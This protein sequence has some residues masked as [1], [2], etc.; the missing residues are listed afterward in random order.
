MTDYSTN[1]VG[2]WRRPHCKGGRRPPWRRPHCR[3]RRPTPRAALQEARAAVA[4]GP[5]EGVAQVALQEERGK[6]RTAGNQGHRGAWQPA[7]GRRGPH[8]KGHGPPWR[9]P[10]CSAGPG[11]VAPP[12]R[13]R[14]RSRLRGCDHNPTRG[15]ASARL[16]PLGLR[17]RERTLRRREPRMRKKGEEEEEEGARGVR[18]NLVSRMH[19]LL[20]NCAFHLPPRPDVRRRA[21]RAHRGRTDVAPGAPRSAGGTPESGTRDVRTRS[22]L[23]PSFFPCHSGGSAGVLHQPQATGR[24]PSWEGP[25]P[26]E[27]GRIA[28]STAR[29][30]AG[31]RDRE[32]AAP[33][34]GPAL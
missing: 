14:G 30:G 22:V 32:R 26:S 34:P 15:T 16:H 5:A 13:Q 10:H 29:P 4:H 11:C 31:G 20:R 8:N 6:G 17:S 18:E 9:R 12:T 25:Y 19:S 21:A 33:P 7:G 2:A 3:G 24:I 23:T 27:E 1:D 28:T